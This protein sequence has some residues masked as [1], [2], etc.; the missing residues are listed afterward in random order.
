MAGEHAGK[1]SEVTVTVSQVKERQLPEADDEFA[2]LAS[3][4]DTLD[5]LK[6][7]LRTRFARV[8]KMEQGSQAR[9]R[10]LDALLEQAD[11]PLPESVVQSEV[12][13]RAHEAVHE[14]DHDEERLNSYVESQGQTREEFDTELRT[15]AEQAVKTQLLLDK[16]ADEANVQVEQNELMERI[17]MQAQRFGVQP[18]G[19]HPAGAAGQPARRGLRRRPSWQGARHGRPGGHDH[20]PRRR[21]GRPLRALRHRRRRRRGGPGGRG[22]RRGRRPDRRRQPGGRRRQRR[23]RPRLAVLA[24]GGRR[25]RGHRGRRRARLHHA[26]LIRPRR[27]GHPSARS[28]HGPSTDC[29]AGRD[30]YC[31]CRWARPTP[32][33]YLSTR[34]QGHR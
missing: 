3:E 9:D 17:M 33:R 13:V 14:F 25:G 26:G 2:Q 20:R 16:I 7:D 1:E 30:G 6:D 24:G 31:R 18:R 19:V 8:K 34:K 22:C 32:D 11:V 21:P 10:V 4:F 12:D 5:E 29:P 23:Q 15:N 27:P 28:E